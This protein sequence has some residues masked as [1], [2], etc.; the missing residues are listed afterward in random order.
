M[1]H[2]DMMNMIHGFVTSQKHITKYR[3]VLSPI[4]KCHLYFLNVRIS[5][6]EHVRG[7]RGKNNLLSE[8]PD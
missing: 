7:E 5:D 2:H 4:T 8:K 6:T 1:S 3:S